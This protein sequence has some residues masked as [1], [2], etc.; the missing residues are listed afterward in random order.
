MALAWEKSISQR[1]GEAI[2]AFQPALAAK[3]ATRAPV[4]RAQPVAATASQNG[5]WMWDPNRRSVLDRPAYDPKERHAWTVDNY[6]R[7]YWVDA[8]GVRHYEP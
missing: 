5:A 4:L 8:Q 6:G 3:S 7:R 2:P 1:V